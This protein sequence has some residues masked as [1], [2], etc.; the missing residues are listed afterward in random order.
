VNISIS[1]CPASLEYDNGDTY[2]EDSLLDAIRSFIEQ[3]HPGAT[4]SCLQIGHRQGDEWARVDGDR[5]AGDDL[6]S[7]FFDLHGADEDLFVDDAT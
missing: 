3:R 7:A 4:I 2:D 6:L 5:D 1:I